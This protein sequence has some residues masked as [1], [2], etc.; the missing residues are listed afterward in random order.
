MTRN[1]GDEQQESD[2]D[3]L[4]LDSQRIKKDALYKP[5]LRKFRAFL[6]KVFDCLGLSKGCNQWAPGRL[7][8]QVQ[9]YAGKIKLPPEL[10][11]V[12]TY[13]KLAVMLFPAIVK[14]N[15]TPNRVV[16]VEN[17]FHI[18]RGT[19]YDIFRENNIQKRLQFFSSP[20]IKVLWSFMI[21]IKPEIVINH[22]RRCRSFPYKGECRFQSLYSDML[23]LERQMKVQLIPEEGRDQKKIKT[24][25]MTEVYEDL[26]QNSKYKNR[27]DAA[28]QK[29]L[30]KIK[31]VQTIRN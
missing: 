26:R 25:S 14:R 29:S 27:N 18:I 8:R 21:K 24:F 10:C 15:H 4:N 31:A 28:I 20:L 9:I 13:A 30:D 22:L 6:R 19:C 7:M 12:E 5:L 16:D 2:S 3:Q 11:T 1:E 17:L 23:D